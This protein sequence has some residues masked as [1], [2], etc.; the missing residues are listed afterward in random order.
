MLKT[1]FVTLLGLFPIKNNGV[2]PFEH[3]RAFRKPI[4][5]VAVHPAIARQQIPKIVAV[6]KAEWNH[7][8]HRIR[9]EQYLV[10]PHAP[11]LWQR[12]ENFLRPTN[13]PLLGRVHD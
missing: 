12:I 8:V 5:F 4:A 9:S 10:R 13:I 2:L 1:P 11:L 3:K 6:P 7:V